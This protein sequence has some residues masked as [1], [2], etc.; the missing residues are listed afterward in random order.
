MLPALL[1]SL[2]P[3]CTPVSA[4]E[5]MLSTE[6]APYGEL[7]TATFGDLSTLADHLYDNACT[8]PGEW[9]TSQWY[10][11][12]LSA[13][14]GVPCSLIDAP[15]AWT[16]CYVD[17]AATL[18][19]SDT[20]ADL[21][22]QCLAPIY[23]QDLAADLAEGGQDAEEL[24]GRAAPLAGIAPAAL[25]VPASLERVPVLVVGRSSEYLETRKQIA[26][27]LLKD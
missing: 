17:T 4:I 22:D 20:A 26:L 13:A 14:D 6:R 25:V 9:A 18:S 23:A 8:L 11:D 12:S 21:E 19:C 7:D 5:E 16:V 15:D 3:S 24:D 27:T 1:L 10:I 2:I